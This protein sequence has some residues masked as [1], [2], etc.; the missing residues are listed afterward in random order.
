MFLGFPPQLAPKRTCAMIQ[1]SALWN[2]ELLFPA[3]MAIPRVGQIDL[4]TGPVK[5]P[6]YEKD[7]KVAELTP[8]CFA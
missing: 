5:V 8:I 7:L 3:K 2:A 1:A 6:L 4:P